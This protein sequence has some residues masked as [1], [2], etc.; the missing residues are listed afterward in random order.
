M[1]LKG[2]DVNTPEMKAH[3]DLAKYG[4]RADQAQRWAEAEVVR[5]ML[6]IMPRKTGNLVGIIQSYNSVINGS[7]VVRAAQ[8]YGVPL[9]SGVS[10]SGRPFNWTN[11]STVPR[12][13]HYTVET[14]KKDIIRGVK[15]IMLGKAP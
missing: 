9:Y 7:G 10:K 12:W 6:P 5:K 2:I 14:Y 1:K 11:P 4:D 15:N 13:G 3:V 8:E